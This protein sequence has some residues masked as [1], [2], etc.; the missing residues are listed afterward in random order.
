MAVVCVSIVGAAAAFGGPINAQAVAPNGTYLGIFEVQSLD[1]SHN[2]PF[3]PAWGKAGTNYSRVAPARYADGHSAPVAGPNS[4]YISNRVFN[5]TGQNIFSE[6]RESQWGNVWG[7]FID[8]TIGDADGATGTDADIPF[9]ASDPLKKFSDTLGMIPFTRSSITPGTGVTNA[10]QQINDVGS[11]IDASAVYGDTASRLDWL[12]S[13]TVDGNPANNSALLM[14]PNGLLPTVAARGDASTAPQMSLD[15]RLLGDPSDAIVAGDVRANENIALTSVQTLFAR[16]HNRIVGLL[17]SYLSREIKFQIARRIVIAEQ[18]YITYTEFL[19]SLGIDLPAYQGYNPFVDANLT[20]EFATVGYRAHSMIHG[21]V[22]VDTNA[23]RY[24][25]ATLDALTAEGIEIDTNGD[26]V[27]I[28][29]P[30]GV[31]FFNPN[32]VGMLQ[33]GPLLAGVGAESEYNND[34]QIDNQ[35]RST[36]FQVP[37]PGNPGCLDG[38]TMPQCFTGVSDLGAIDIE[39]GRDHGMPTYNQM[40]VAYGLPRATSF[41]QITGESSAKFPSD[42]LLTPG[43]E[44][45]DPNSLDFTALYDVNGNPVAL[46][47]PDAQNI[48]TRGIRRTP[49]AARLKAIYRNVNKVD[50]FVGMLAE[51]HLSGTE[52]GALQKAIWTRQFESL[53]DGDRFYYGDD[54]SLGVIRSLFGI[55]FHHSL[56]QVIAANTDVPLAQLKANVFKLDGPNAT[57]TTKTGYPRSGISDG[58]RAPGR[59]TDVQ[60]ATA[61]NRP[62]PA[63]RAARR[64]HASH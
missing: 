64:G 4:R 27:E 16:E 11:Y 55:D 12:R 48:A 53:R 29:V 34:E 33:L 17:P 39:R 13:G 35:L 20:N 50:A 37:V 7:Q 1:G 61:T 42:P 25:Q 58:H 51:P 15:G 36:L 8:H 43:H 3:F 19:P 45:N 62:N 23:S 46:G 56:A 2:N 57:S 6:N 24:T 26:D 59:H 47:S 52:M 41:T 21:D 9:H 49:L 60:V 54:P 32:L 22:E 10:A 44:I 63:N 14:M 28:A 31:A 5:D 18:Q 38:P 30:L 40:R